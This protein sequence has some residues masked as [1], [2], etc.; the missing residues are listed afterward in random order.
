MWLFQ[1]RPGSS[2]AFET[3]FL[4]WKNKTVASIRIKPALAISSSGEIFSWRA[5]SDPSPWLLNCLWRTR[6]KCCR[7][8]FGCHSS[9]GWCCGFFSPPPP[10]SVWLP[11]LN[12]GA[13][14]LLVILVSPAFWDRCTVR[15]SSRTH[16]VSTFCFQSH[17]Q[18]KP[19]AVSLNVLQV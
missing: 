9:S 12:R 7:C 16:V 19:L 3:T 5:T 13:Q 2:Q 17:H 10:A 6:R 11:E 15:C 1:D 18:T 8:S 14:A 4:P